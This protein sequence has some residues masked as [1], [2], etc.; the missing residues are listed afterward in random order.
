MKSLLFE[1]RKNFSKPQLITGYTRSASGKLKE[2]TAARHIQGRHRR[3]IEPAL[4]VGGSGRRQGQ[5]GHRRRHRGLEGGDGALHRQG[6]LGR[7]P[8]QNRTLQV[9][10]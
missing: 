7:Q 2:D 1:L 6:V 8:P 3:P 10:S 9:S 5:P 4:E